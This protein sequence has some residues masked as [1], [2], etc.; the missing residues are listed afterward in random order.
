MRMR[1]KM[2]VEE[3]GEIKQT[4]DKENFE[5]YIEQDLS[6][7]VSDSQWERISDD[8]DGRLANF[9]DSIM[10]DTAQDFKE[11]WYDEDGNSSAT[12]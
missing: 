12:N 1:L 9:I 6:V 3:N 7:K 2:S 4:I 10:Q 5:S 8:L 11:G